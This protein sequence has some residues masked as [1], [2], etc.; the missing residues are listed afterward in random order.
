MGTCGYREGW[1]TFECGNVS[2]ENAGYRDLNKPGS[3]AVHKEDFSTCKNVECLASLGYNALSEG[4][5]TLMHHVVQKLKKERKMQ[6]TK[7]EPPSRVKRLFS[8]NEVL[9]TAVVW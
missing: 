4:Y 7:V 6:E 9:C 2:T 1:M 3:I 8:T 5:E